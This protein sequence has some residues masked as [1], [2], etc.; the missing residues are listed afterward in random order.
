MQARQTVQRMINTLENYVNIPIL[1]FQMQRACTLCVSTL[2]ASKN[3][4]RPKCSSYLSTSSIIFNNGSSM[5]VFDRQAK[6][7]QTE[8]SARNP[9]LDSFD[10]LKEEI[11]Y[12]LADRVLDVSRK[13]EVC[14]DIGSGRGWVSRHLTE[15]SIGR[16]TAIDLSESLLKTAPD[17]PDVPVEKLVMDVDGTDLPFQDNSVDIVTSSLSLHWVNDL[18]KLFKEINRILKPDG[19][20]IG[21]M[22]GGDT[23]VELRVALQLAETEREGGFSPHISPFVEVRD[24]GSILNKNNFTMI[25]IDTDDL[26]VKYASIF[27]LMRDLKGMAENNA[28]YN[29][30]LHLH[31]E[32]LFAANAIYTD[33]YANPDGSLPASFQVYYWIGWKPDPS[34]PKP[35]KPQKSD[36]SLKDLHRLDEVA[37]AYGIVDLP[38]EDK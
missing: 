33:L 26:K 1:F 8:R 22:F 12:R 32:T 14:V 31:R 5:Q 30:K 23:L 3:V 36:V 24:I 13:M 38:K 17:P 27:P 4:F 21:G 7:L 2:C 20:F 10:F 18:P 35:L 6:L 16:L 11:G 37:Q 25:T 34:Q 9:E 19:V 28:A 29:R 15:H